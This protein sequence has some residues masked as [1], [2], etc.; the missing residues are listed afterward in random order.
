MLWLSAAVVVCT[1]S[2][3]LAETF[4]VAPR[5]ATFPCRCRF[6]SSAEYPWASTSPRG[7]CPPVPFGRYLAVPPE[8]VLAD[9]SSIGCSIVLIGRRSG[10][11]SYL[12]R[13]RSAKSVRGTPTLPNSSLRFASEHTAKTCDDRP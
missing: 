6:R 4:S 8:I 10:I 1:Q 7:R 9:H 12:N 3:S 11:T 13:P 5:L 2:R